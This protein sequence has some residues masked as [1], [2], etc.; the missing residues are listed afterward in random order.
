MVYKV[1]SVTPEL[2]LEWNSP[3]CLRIYLLS[4]LDILSTIKLVRDS[5][6]ESVDLFRLEGVKNT[7]IER[8]FFLN[9]LKEKWKTKFLSEDHKIELVIRLFFAN[10]NLL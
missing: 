5:L 10:D 3:G 1:A 2:E 4:I 9:V 8:T 6:N 7:F